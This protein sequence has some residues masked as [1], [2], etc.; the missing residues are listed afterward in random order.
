LGRNTILGRGSLLRRQFLN[1]L[2]ILIGNNKFTTIVDNVSINYYF[3]GL[4]DIKSIMGGYD[5]KE[6][7]FL[8]NNMK[9]DSIFLD[10]GANY[11]FYTQFIATKSNFKKIIAIEPNPLMVQRINENINLTISVPRYEGFGLTPIES[12]ACGI[13]VICSN[14]GAFNSMIDEGKT[15]HMLNDYS[16]NELVSKI[17][18]Y[19][20]NKEKLSEMKAHCIN[21]VNNNFTIQ[22]EAK[23]INN[24][25]KKILRKEIVL[26]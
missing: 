4:S 10:I 1:L 7:N 13:P 19:I 24:V 22:R 11:G 23:S 2:K 21:K 25:Y 14:T 26:R 16:V 18:Y 9:N 3:D 20:K 5:Q 12:M 6:L 15:G 17:E 8:I